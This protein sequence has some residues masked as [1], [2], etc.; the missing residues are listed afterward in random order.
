MNNPSKINNPYSSLG[1]WGKLNPGN[2][3]NIPDVNP[4]NTGPLAGLG[5][6]LT[7]E[8]INNLNIG[9]DPTQHNGIFGAAGNALQE[10]FD[11]DSALG[12]SMWGGLDAKTGQVSK[13]IIPT[14]FGI[15]NSL[16]NSWLGMQQL[17]LAKDQFNFQKD[18]FNKQYD[19]QVSLTN[20]NLRDRQTARKSFSGDRVED[21]ESYMKKNG[22]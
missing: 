8:E 1:T 22:V 18:A 6:V 4:Q 16:A 2:I 15:A 19:N 5:G 21:T 10:F 11:T 9:F 17:D 14:G 3:L 20:T 13:G 7:P 12:K